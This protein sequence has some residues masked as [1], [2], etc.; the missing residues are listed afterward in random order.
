[1]AEILWDAAQLL[2]IRPR[3]ASTARNPFSAGEPT[4]QVLQRRERR[5]VRGAEEL[6]L[7]VPRARSAST[8]RRRTES[9]LPQSMATH[10]SLPGRL[11]G[12]G[13]QEFAKIR[14]VSLWPSSEA[15]GRLLPHRTGPKS[16]RF[17]R[18]A[19]SAS[20]WPVCGPV[21][22]LRNRGPVELDSRQSAAGGLLVE[23][24]TTAEFIEPL[25]EQGVR[26][27]STSALAACAAFWGSDTM[28]TRSCWPRS[29]SNPGQ[30]FA[31]RRGQGRPGSRWCNNRSPPGP[32]RLLGQFAE[33]VGSNQKSLVRRAEAMKSWT[34]PRLIEQMRHPLPPS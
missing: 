19:S 12:Q 10:E 28:A 7:L 24:G 9:L 31:A 14:T 2:V 6:G 20:A 8:S 27:W 26:T 5:Y 4:S 15:M 32:A 11:V 25:V 30:L 23:A 1:M 29:A 13:V 34:G 22:G 21:P 17:L 16:L 33:Q 18:A 3:P